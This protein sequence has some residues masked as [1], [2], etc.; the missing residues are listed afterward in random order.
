MARA[1]SGFRSLQLAEAFSLFG[2]VLMDMTTT[3]ELVSANEVKHRHEY[4]RWQS[5]AD[6]WEIASPQK[7][8]ARNDV[9]YNLSGAVGHG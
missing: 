9:S 5:P 6:Q 8:A 7:D 1:S 2:G 4:S 3:K